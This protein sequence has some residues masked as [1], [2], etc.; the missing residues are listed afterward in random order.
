MAEYDEGGVGEVGGGMVALAGEVKG[1]FFYR[2]AEA[3]RRVLYEG[4]AKGSSRRSKLTAEGQN[5]EYAGLNYL[6]GGEQAKM[7]ALRSGTGANK[8][9]LEGMVRKKWLVREAV[10]EER[11][12]RRLEKIAVLAHSSGSREEGVGS[13][14]QLPG[15]GGRLPR[16]NENQ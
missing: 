13:R 5:R 8:S 7:S 12:A 16:L 15:V 9:L 3:G 2:I 4:A 1:H 11:D 6:E 14:E 10:A